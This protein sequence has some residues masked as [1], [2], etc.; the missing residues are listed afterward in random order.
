M[1]E[2][3][4]LF[5]APMVR[6]L[7]DGRKSVT[8]RL[9]KQWLNVKAGDRLWVRETWWKIPE[10]TSRQLREGADT[11][12]K[13]EYAADCSAIETEQNRAMGWVIK[14][15][16]FMPRWASRI[17]LECEEDARVERLRD[18]TEDEAIAEGIKP[19]VINA[20]TR[21]VTLWHSLHT[22]PGECWEDNPQ[23]V[24]V[25][26]FRVISRGLAARHETESQPVSNTPGRRLPA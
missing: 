1:K 9:S 6:A 23:V 25:G 5:S 11:W 19:D 16:I 15:S 2:H 13:V 26:R 24:R 7:L 8:R 10:P 12:P 20:I 18:I 22:K 14:P 4:I 17:L 3:P 21:F